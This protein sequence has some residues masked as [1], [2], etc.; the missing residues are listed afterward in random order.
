MSDP[1]VEVL[2]L[3]AD[4]KDRAD[5]ISL[6]DSASSGYCN[7][8]TGDGHDATRLCDRD[9]ASTLILK[10]GAFFEDSFPKGSLSPKGVLLPEGHRSRRRN[11][12]SKSG[13]LNHLLLVTGKDIRNRRI[14]GWYSTG[15]CRAGC[16]S[17]GGRSL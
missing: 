8:T 15:W 6:E 12:L 16:C 5:R 3:D 14:T 4:P 11:H 13:R 9:I 17:T 7:T 10:A 1:P 2:S